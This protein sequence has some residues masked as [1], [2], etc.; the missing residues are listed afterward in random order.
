MT[1]HP[2]RLLD[3]MR[4]VLRTKHYSYHTEKA[5][6]F[7]VKRYILFHGRRHPK[8]LAEPEVEAFLSHLAMERR[9]ALPHRTRRSARS[10][11]STAMCWTG[12]WK[13]EST[14]CT[15]NNPNACRWCSPPRKC[16]VSSTRWTAYTNYR[17]SCYMAVACDCGSVWDYGSRISTSD[18]GRS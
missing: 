9:V 13:R 2:P 18:N 15:P 7:W 8:E 5:Y 16:F 10:C 11:F 12:R 4:A 6:V 14:R 17:F 3:R 1:D